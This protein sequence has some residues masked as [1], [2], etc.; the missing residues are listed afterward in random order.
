[1]SILGN[2]VLH[3]AAVKSLIL[4]Q[5]IDDKIRVKKVVRRE[6]EEEKK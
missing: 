1:M 5:S 3:F 6:E 2:H 4:L